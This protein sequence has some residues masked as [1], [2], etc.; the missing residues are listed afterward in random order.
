MNS[1]AKIACA[2]EKVLVVTRP[3][4]IYLVEGFFWFGALTLLGFVADY[5]QFR[6]MQAYGIDFD[7]SF[8][9]FRMTEDTMIAPWL[10][11]LMGFMIFWPL[12][13][14]YIATVVGLT[15][16]RVIIKRG[17]L[18]VEVEQVDMENIDAETVH[19][20]MLGWMF[21]YGRVYL[22]CRFVGDVWLPAIRQPYKLLKTMQ[23]AKKKHPEMPYNAE[24][25][26]DNIVRLQKL[27]KEN[28]FLK[29]WTSAS[30]RPA[31]NR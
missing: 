7:L 19:H 30:R 22:D 23:I 31:N 12:F 20:G 16:Q 17:L 15:N 26:E 29:N 18:F 13:S 8:W 21:G 27:E 1:I 6:F 10:F 9:K 5:Y 2:D 14:T 25:L 3:H 28:T 4:W 24:T 11:A